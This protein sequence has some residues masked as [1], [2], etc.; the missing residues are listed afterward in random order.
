[1]TQSRATDVDNSNGSV[2]VDDWG[3]VTG[4]VDS[5]GTVD[6]NVSGKS[7]DMN[8]LR[9]Q[10]TFANKSSLKT[11]LNIVADHILIALNKLNV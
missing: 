10:E 3:R 5:S 1:M 4:V 2:D 11:K 7:T 8:D 9:Y 6:I